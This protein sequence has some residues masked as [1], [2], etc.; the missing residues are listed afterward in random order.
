MG[1]VLSRAT[2]SVTALLSA[3][4]CKAALLYR[5]MFAPDCSMTE[6]MRFNV[7]V[8]ATFLL[9]VTRDTCVVFSLTESVSF[10]ACIHDQFLTN[11][12]RY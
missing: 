6:L 4:R 12:R 2:R 8:T 9:I 5:R 1:Q 7:T 3:F 11:V 10:L